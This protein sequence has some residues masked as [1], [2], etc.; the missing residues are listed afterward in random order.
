MRVFNCITYAKV[1]N[2]KRTKLDAKGI[3]CL[4]VRSC[5]D[6]KSYRLTCLESQKI[7][8]SPNVVFF[9]DKRLLEEGSSRNIGQEALEVDHSSKSDYDDEEENSE[10]KTKPSEEN[11]ASTTKVEANE[12]NTITKPSI[13]KHQVQIKAMQQL[14]DQG[15]HHVY[16]SH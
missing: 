15:T 10:V 7:I 4:F 9:E 1:P 13:S 12:D 14:K 16:A 2:E 8:K 5:E 3:K 11:E 6:T